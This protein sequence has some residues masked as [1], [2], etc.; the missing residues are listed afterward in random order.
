MTQKLSWWACASTQQKLA[1]IDGGIELG[2][3]G[4]HIAINVGAPRAAVLDFG[5]RHG[6]TFLAGATAAQRR[7]DL[8]AGLE[9]ARRRGKLD[10]DIASAFS[11]FGGGARDAPLLDEVPV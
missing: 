7:A 11:I 4:R 3:S 2:L 10:C 8:A 5:H 6:R 9:R 1:Q